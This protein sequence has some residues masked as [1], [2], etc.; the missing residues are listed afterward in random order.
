MNHIEEIRET[1]LGAADYAYA[2]CSIDNVDHLLLPVFDAVFKNDLAK[3]DG[4]VLNGIRSHG[5]RQYTAQ[6]PG[7][8]MVGVTATVTAGTGCQY[9]PIRIEVTDCHH[10]GHVEEEPI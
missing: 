1:A 8:G 3:I 4:F 2:S 6:I 9:Q 5:V 7:A 10:A